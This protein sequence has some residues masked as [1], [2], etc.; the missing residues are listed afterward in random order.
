MID[1]AYVT[2][3]GPGTGA[4]APR[5][6]LASDAPELILDGPWRFRLVGGLTDLLDNPWVVLGAVLLGLAVGVP[7]G[8]GI[9]RVRAVLDA[10]WAR[11][12]AK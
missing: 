9:A 1:L 5:A 4:R 6:R 12:A 2:D 7:A 3:L 11:L 10:A 8:Y